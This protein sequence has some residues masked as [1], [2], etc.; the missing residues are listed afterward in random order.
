MPLLGPNLGI[1][2][3]G[4]SEHESH[5]EPARLYPTDMFVIPALDPLS[6][7]GSGLIETLS[8]PPIIT[9]Q[10]GCRRAGAVVEGVGS[11]AGRGILGRIRL[12]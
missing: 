3:V 1:E 11:S 6:L 5:I 9:R 10:G 4:A 7:Y 12:S 2:P 8:P